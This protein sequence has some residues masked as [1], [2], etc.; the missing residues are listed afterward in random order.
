M[1]NIPLV[2]IHAVD[3]LSIDEVAMPVPGPDDVVVSVRSCGICGSDLS[4]VKLGGLHPDPDEPSPLGH[5]FSGV[6]HAVGERVSHLSVGD[7]VVVNPEAGGNG[8]GGVGDQGGFSPYV[9]VRNANRPGTSED[10]A[11]VLPLPDSLSD[12]IGAMIEP[13]SV[14]LHGLRRVDTTAQDTVV[15]MGGGTIGL[16]TLLCAQHIGCTDTVVLDLN[17]NRLSLA[18]ELGAHALRGDAP[19]VK[20]QLG[21]ILG[22][23]PDY[24]HQPL[25]AA[26]VYVEAT[27][28]APALDTI[29]GIAA[30]QSR[31]ALVGANMG[32][33]QIQ[34]IDFLMKE[35]TLSGS[36]AYCDEFEQVIAMLAEGK[37]DPTRL[38]SHRFPLSDFH[39]AFAAA[40]CQDSA[41]KVMVDCQQ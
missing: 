21:E 37:V 16:C 30:P 2:R 6:I 25:P 15:I 40:Q 29:L 18:R 14:A 27:G 20:E 13:M 24:M 9:L 41:I 39:S 7:R 12:E 5:E 23:V 35:L 31:I 17:E 8:I 34:P 4:Y 1:S 19:D 10:G 28:A 33:Q 32:A 36:M 22:T 26:S 3:T 11:S 38:I